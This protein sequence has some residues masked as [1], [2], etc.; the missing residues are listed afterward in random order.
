MKLI[1]NSWILKRKDFVLQD[2][3]NSKYKKTKNCNIVL[4]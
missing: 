4:Q 2:N 3:N 1:V